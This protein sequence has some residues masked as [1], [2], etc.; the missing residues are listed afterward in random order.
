MRRTQPE[1][2]SVNKEAVV[3][4]VETK[5]DA[6]SIGDEEQDKELEKKQRRKSTTNNPVPIAAPNTTDTKPHHVK[7]AS[8][9]N[10]SLPAG[11]TPTTATS[12]WSRGTTPATNTSNTN[13]GASTTENNS[14]SWYIPY[15][16]FLIQFK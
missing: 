7:T 13:A 9:D 4:S 12:W 14:K 2:P 1:T 11:T 16:L 5:I 8:V 10:K 6:F 15:F 3:P